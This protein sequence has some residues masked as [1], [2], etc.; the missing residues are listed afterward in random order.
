MVVSVKSKGK[1]F[2][3]IECGKSFT[4]KGTLKQ[5]Y[6]VHTQEKPHTCRIC[7]KSFRVKSNLI[8]HMRIHTREKPFVCSE[9]GKGFNQRENL[10]SHIVFHTNEKPFS[11]NMCDKSFKYSTSFRNHLNT[12]LDTKPYS[13]PECGRGFNRS[14][15]LKS[16]MRVH[17]KERPFIYLFSSNEGKEDAAVCL[18]KMEVIDE[19]ITIKEELVLPEDEQDE[20]NERL[21]ASKSIDD[22]NGHFNR[23]SPSPEP[24]NSDFLLVEMEELSDNENDEKDVQDPLGGL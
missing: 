20:R 19:F 10:N 23:E 12:H 13:C 8:T 7:E 9:C 15:D 16:H 24:L 1:L 18:Q 21:N 2:S 14:G 5:H 17:T 22:I 3:C 4:R 11:C 6:S